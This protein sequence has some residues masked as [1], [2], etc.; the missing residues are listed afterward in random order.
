MNPNDGIL[1]ED[2]NESQWK[3]EDDMIVNDTNSGTVK[4]VKLNKE[5]IRKKLLQKS[6]ERHSELLRRLSKT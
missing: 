3:G 4:Q 5:Q 1:P 2:I 6:T